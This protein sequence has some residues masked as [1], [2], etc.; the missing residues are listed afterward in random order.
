[1]QGD[2]IPGS[3]VN[4][5]AGFPV[6]VTAQYYHFSANVNLGPNSVGDPGFVNKF[7]LEQNYPNPFNPSTKI[8]FS[9]PERTEVSLKVYNVLGKEVAT[10]LNTVQDAGSHEI[11]FD[12]SN[13]AS[14]LYIYTI[15]AGKFSQS[16]KMMLLK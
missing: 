11:N 4:A 12:A 9:I 8:K 15:N 6:G 14:G 13:L 10:I 7:D 5:L 2:T 3:V 1:M 16:K